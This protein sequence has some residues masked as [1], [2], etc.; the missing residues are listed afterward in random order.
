MMRDVYRQARKVLIW[1]GEDEEGN[2]LKPFIKLAQKM[3]ESDSK[4]LPKN[5]I[6]KQKSIGFG[7][8]HVLALSSLLGRPWFRRIWVVQE[9]AMAREATIHCGN[10]SLPWE[11]FCFILELENGINTL[12][13]NNQIV[14]DIVEGIVF[15]RKAISQGSETSLLQVL[16]RHRASLATDPRDKIYA[17]LGLCNDNLVQAD[18]KLGVPDLHRLLTQ[19][20]LRQH[21]KLDVITVPSSPFEQDQR[22]NPSWVPDWSALDAAFPLALRTQL[23]NDTEY[24][25]TGQ[26]TWKPAFSADDAMLGVEAQF[27]DDITALGDVRH[28]YRPKEM[29][30]NSFFKQL[31]AEFRVGQEWYRICLG[32]AT[33][34]EAPYRTG[35]TLFD[36]CWQ[37]L[38]AG[39]PRSDFEE[40]KKQ[41]KTIWKMFRWYLW[42]SRMHLLPLVVFKMMDA[43]AKRTGKSVFIRRMINAGTENDFQFKVRRQYN[44]EI[45]M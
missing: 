39:C 8:D 22:T 30:L 20:H 14:M 1:L 32:N 45:E 23:T 3:T 43:I 2:A 31:R 37:I 24:S 5:R 35:E 18:Y 34:W 41:A 15:E 17:L 29:D 11:E 25:A 12:G 7:D 44:V 13:V 40:S 33:S 10:Q 26:S 9:V 38:L 21:C 27:L 28:P 4:T 42:A 36:V 19:A 16:L 6:S